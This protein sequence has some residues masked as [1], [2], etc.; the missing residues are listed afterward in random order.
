MVHEPEPITLV[1]CAQDLHRMCGKQLVLC[2]CVCWGGGVLQHTATMITEI[3]TGGDNHP[4]PS[5]LPMVCSINSKRR[6]RSPVQS[7]TKKWSR[8]L[9]RLSCVC[10][11]VCVCACC[12]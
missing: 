3:I 4:I 6:Q 12:R 11:C 5:V 8:L 2:V 7:K 1:G 9:N 10:V